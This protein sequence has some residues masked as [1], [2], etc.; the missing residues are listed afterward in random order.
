MNV[1][2][3]RKLTKAETQELTE[4]RELIAKVNGRIAATLKKKNGLEATLIRV[5]EKLIKLRDD[6]GEDEKVVSQMMSTER[7]KQLLELSIAR[8]N[9]EQEGN[10][11]D[12]RRVAC[13]CQ[14]TICESFAK[15]M[16][17]HHLA[18]ITKAFRRFYRTEHEAHY[19]ASETHFYQAVE[20]WLKPNRG[21]YG[22]HRNHWSEATIFTALAEQQKTVEALLEGADFM[23]GIELAA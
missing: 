23:P 21:I 19:L 22:L 12:A 11:E 4:Y 9:K 8:A 18:E 3:H 14:A 20:H 2:L 17:E 7:Q 10:M 1:Q 13:Q 6:T 5:L 15:G 16:K